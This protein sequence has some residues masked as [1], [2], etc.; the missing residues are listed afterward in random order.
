MFKHSA[1]S[2]KIHNAVTK[3]SL[4]DEFCYKEII[5]FKK[6]QSE[7]DSNFMENMTKELFWALKKSVIRKKKR[8]LEPWW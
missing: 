4:T 6:G 3:I 2:K 8:I 1:V 7:T 5:I